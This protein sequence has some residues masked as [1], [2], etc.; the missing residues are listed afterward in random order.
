MQPSTR[1][2]PTFMNLWNAAKK[3]TLIADHIPR[4]QYGGIVFLREQYLIN[5]SYNLSR[6]VEELYME[7]LRDFRAAGLPM[8]FF[9]RPYI[10]GADFDFYNMGR[11]SLKPQYI[12]LSSPLLFQEFLREMGTQAQF[13]IE[14]QYPDNLEDDYV[15]EYQIESTIYAS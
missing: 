5:S 15:C 7:I 4:I 1:F 11:T 12:D 2:D 13:L 6:P 9:I 8:K 3:E 14:E 10:N